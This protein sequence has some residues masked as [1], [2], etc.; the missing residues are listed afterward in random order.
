MSKPSKTTLWI[1]IAIFAL[2]VTYLIFYASVNDIDALR[3]QA[4]ADQETIANLEDL[5]ER[6]DFAWTA[7][8]MEIDNLEEIIASKDEL[9]L[10]LKVKEEILELYKKALETSYTYVYYTQGLLDREGIAYAEFIVESVL[11]DL[12]LEEIEEQ[13]EFFESLEE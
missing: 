4:K 3:L 8:D 10:Q 1:I 5:V 2:V 11:D 6:K 7:A 12:Y 9:I 13:I